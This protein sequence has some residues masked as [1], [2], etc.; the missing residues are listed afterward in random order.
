MRYPREEA[1]CQC[2]RSHMGSAAEGAGLRKKTRR[3]EACSAAVPNWNA[4]WAAIATVVVVFAVVV[5]GGPF[6]WAIA[7]VIG[8]GAW[9]IQKRSERAREAQHR[10]V[11]Q[12]KEEAQKQLEE[13]ERARQAERARKEELRREARRQEEQAERFRAESQTQTEQEQCQEAEEAPQRSRENQM[14]DESAD[15]HCERA[16]WSILEVAPTASKDEIV[17]KYRGKILQCHPDRVAALDPAFTRLAEERTKS[18]N[19][20]YAQAMNARSE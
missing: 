11:E 2:A 13:A 15:A 14:D 20:A 8:G 1:A 16:W 17:R 10:K 6:G 19:S 9:L 12:L 18:L 3:L 4:N 7:A 5:F